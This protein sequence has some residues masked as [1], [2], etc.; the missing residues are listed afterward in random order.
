MNR[1]RFALSL[2]AASVL[3]VG[4][5]RADAGS[6]SVSQPVVV[7]VVGEPAGV[8]VLHEDFRTRD[9][10]TPRYPSDMPRPVMVAL[11]ADGN[12]SVARSALEAGPLGHM[13]PGV[14]YG[15]AGT[16]LLL[17]NAGAGRYDGV[18]SD[19]LHATGV[20]DS[21]TGT[22]DGTDQQALVVLVLS[23]D[24]DS[25][26]P[27]LA[28]NAWIDLA[29]T[30]D[31]SIHTTSDPTQCAGAD[32]VRSFTARGH[33]L[34]SSAG[35]TT[36]QPEPL[37]APNGLPQT[38]IVGGVDS[39]G[40]TW[41]PGHPAET[42]PFYAAGNVVRPY[43]TGAPFSYEAAAPDSFTGL[44]HFGGTSGATPLTAGW[45]AQL[46]SYARQRLH[47]TLGTVRGA[48]ATGPAKPKVGPLSDGRF[49]NAELRGLLH[50][51]AIQH[52]GLPPGAAYGAEGYGA[53]NA[54]S[55]SRAEQI[56]NGSLATP[57]R[58]ADDQAY[59]TIQQVRAEV[60]ARCG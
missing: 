24:P 55:I 28:R 29:S 60:F 21:I 10:R 22:R 45:A 48:L 31:Y 15:V 52:S 33:L 20:A 3:L 56:L 34:F 23:N 40:N 59:T 5:G 36:D 16:R 19:A 35:N 2:L 17:V 27:W 4:V 50:A 7:A 11:P 32:D 1:G 25:V 14:L 54:A 12:F 38:Y 39:A 18:Q 42:D 57:G 46:V 41:F 47:S 44:T 37:V 8:N 9:G 49:T 51:V 6:A 30:S 26:Y 53:L 43:E 58:A 13:T